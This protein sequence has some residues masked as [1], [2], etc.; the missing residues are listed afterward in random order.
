MARNI[1]IKATVADL[2]SLEARVRA[3]ATDGPVAL[4]QD[5]TFF[6]CGD[7]RLKL[8][9]IADRS[10]ELIFYRRADQS[11]PKMSFYLRS[12]TADP[13]G[14]RQALTLAYGQD[15]RVI[16]QRTLYRVGRT[17]V[18]LDR[19]QGLGDFMELEVVLQDDDDADEGVAEARALMTRLGIDDA[20]LIEDAYIDRLRDPGLADRRA[21]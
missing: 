16:K 3:V 20:S 21:G 13:D 6:R 1:E 15:G 14:L 10:A 4:A 19:V 2:V 9:V 5:D 18:H 7:G 12:P 17:R 11:G 8:R